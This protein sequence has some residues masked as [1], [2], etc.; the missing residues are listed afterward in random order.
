M[1]VGAA[2][3]L[4]LALAQ[5]ASALKVRYKQELNLVDA[6]SVETVDVFCP[7]ELHVTGGGAFSNGI[8]QGTKIQDSYPIDGEDEGSKPDDGWR[9]TIWNASANSVNTE[10]QAICTKLKPKYKT[11]LFTPTI[12]TGRVN[13]ADGTSASGGGISV[14]E[15]FAFPYELISSRPSAGTQSDS[16]S[17]Y[18]I[19]PGMAATQSI[20][21]GICVSNDDARLRTRVG[22]VDV[23]GDNQG[24]G[25]VLCKPKEKVLGVGAAANTQQAALVTIFG[26]DSLADPDTKLDDGATITVDHFGMGSVGSEAYA[27]CAK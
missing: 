16:W 6:D 18:V 5:P 21:Y 13:C 23:P 12:D 20:A 19:G 14:N 27:V 9:A 1:A 26:A 8:Y 25:S 3:A 17:D 11:K 7:K 4:G 2:S 22:S 24:G 15:S 10:A